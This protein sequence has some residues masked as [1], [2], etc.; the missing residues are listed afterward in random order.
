MMNLEVINLKSRKKSI[1]TFLLC[2]IFVVV[3]TSCSDNY[4]N[5]GGDDMKIDVGKI[6][7]EN[8]KVRVSDFKFEREYNEQQEASTLIDVSRVVIDVEVGNINVS[9]NTG[10][11]AIINVDY[12]AST[13]KE[14]DLNTILAQTFLSVS[15]KDGAIYVGIKERDSNTSIW[16][17][18]DENIS[19]YNLSADVEISLPREI[20]NFDVKSDVGNISMNSLKGS[21]TVKS[22]T[23][24]IEA[25]DI[26]FIGISKIELDTGDIDLSLSSNIIDY[27]D[28]EI[29]TDTGNIYVS[30]NGLPYVKTS[31]EQ[32]DFSS[33]YKSIIVNEKCKISAATDTGE[34]SVK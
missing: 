19:K 8:P 6:K 12:Y 28:A 34:V 3:L 20:S 14:K 21:F 17:W 30:L 27:F 2:L 23:G 29:Y 7:V 26:N 11:V 31:S 4:E 9:Y 33:S 1:L 22:D 25:N 13:L 24:N 16:S 10:S 15:V 5:A 18:L 32:G